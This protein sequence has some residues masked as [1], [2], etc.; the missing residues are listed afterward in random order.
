MKNLIADRIYRA[1]IYVRLSKE[2]GD[3]EESDSIV[4][5]KELIRNYLADKSDI[6]ICAEC[7]DD[8]YSGANFDRPHF[9][10]MINE[11]EDGKIDCVIVKDLSR[12]GRNFVEAGRYID[13]IF[14]ALGVRF[15]AVNDN[16]DS[17]NGRTS[18][19][20][21]LIPFKNLINDAY[22]RDIS[23]KVRSQLEIKRK[24]GDF[25]GSFAVFGY[26]KDPAD[27]HKL[28]VDDFAAGIVG[29]IFRWKL[30]GASQQRIADKL[31]E[32]G[33]LSPMEYKRFCGTAYK[34]GFQASTKAKWTAVAVGRILHNEFYIGTLVQ[35]KRT[36][37]NHKVKKTV[38]KPS[39]EWVRI[40]NSHPPI[41]ERED[42][43]AVAKL[44][45]QDTRIAPKKET[46]YLFS[47]LV[48]CADCKQNMVRNS[49]CQNGKRYV[50]Y[51]CGNNRTNKVCSSHRISEPAL[52]EAVFLSLK[53]HIA[54]ILDME[55]ILAYIETLPI[56]QAEVQ[57]AD[58]QL[59]KKQE[60][61]AR[62][63]RLKASLYESLSDGLMDKS[64]Y[65]ELKASYDRKIADAQESERKLKEE[66]ENLLQNRGG[67]SV[68]IE[69][70]KE[71]RNITELTRR[72]AVT[73]I[74]RIYVYEDSRIDICFKYQ[75][76]YDRALGLIQSIQKLQSPDVPLPVKEAV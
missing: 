44:L 40:E 50:Y 54:N 31:N 68:W 53:E 74:D 63:S 1:A 23:I 34:S 8:G 61:L 59:V 45:L 4:N 18:S 64:E 66:L 46:V 70:F 41:V 73:L 27:R 62:Y 5:Q 48:F 17:I 36:T 65:L 19:D 49:V 67:S 30:E 37:P 33:V 22:C 28:I 60:E 55:Q 42:F 14:P 21:I 56:H 10:K 7:V 51:L 76:D 29:D 52:T 72:I 26:L 3:K 57:K 69:R 2:D 47:G 58:A 13:Q 38:Q 16:F 11:I 24:K 12:F 43:Y 20:K 9:K 39:E 25:I 6:Q 32:L 71:H 35:G 15:I 75:Y